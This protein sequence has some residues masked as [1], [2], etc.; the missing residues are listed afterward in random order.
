MPAIDTNKSKIKL[1]VGTPGEKTQNGTWYNYLTEQKLSNKE[2]ISKMKRRILDK[3]YKGSFIKAKFYDNSSGELLE[4]IEGDHR[5]SDKEKAKI[6]LWVGFPDVKDNNT[7]YN[8]NSENTLENTEIIEAMTN[9]ILT[10][11][12][13]EHFNIAIFYE[14]HFGRSLKEIKGKL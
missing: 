2:I 4:T 14:N 1:W 10:G 6:K 3:K 12:Y 8:F 13:K 9:R 11:I 7:W 5:L